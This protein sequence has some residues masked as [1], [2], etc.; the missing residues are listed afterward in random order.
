MQ[1]KTL[2]A[3][4]GE[5]LKVTNEWAA[6]AE[7]RGTTVSSSVWEFTGAGSLASEALSDTTASVLLTPTGSG[8]L[9][10]T[11]TLANGEVLIAWRR[12]QVE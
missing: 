2:Y 3:V 5:T 11:A 9:R 12:V 10:N 1:L 7:K 6:Q 4:E 8:E